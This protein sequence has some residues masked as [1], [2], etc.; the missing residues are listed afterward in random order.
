MNSALYLTLLALY[1]HLGWSWASICC[2]MIPSRNMSR[3][4]RCLLILLWPISLILTDASM[5]E[6]DDNE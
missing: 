6:D 3:Y 4:K 5:E 2:R 1:L